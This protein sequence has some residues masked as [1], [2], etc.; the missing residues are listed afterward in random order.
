MGSGYRNSFVRL[1]YCASLLCPCGRLLSPKAEGI[2]CDANSPTANSPDP[3]ARRKHPRCPDTMHDGGLRLFLS[4]PPPRVMQDPEDCTPIESINIRKM[5][6]VGTRKPLYEMLNL[7]QTGSSHLAEVV[8]SDDCMTLVGIVTLEDVIEE[9]IGEEI[10]DE[11]DEKQ[12]VV[13]CHG[14]PSVQRWRGRVRM[15]CHVDVCADVEFDGLC[16]AP[17]TGR[18]PDNGVSLILFS[19]RTALWARG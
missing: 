8:D 4:P 18:S 2:S 11:T 5:P 19:L 10:I 7:F 6:T 3:A 9:L 14:H 1:E 15:V 16:C 13:H 12:K 17:M